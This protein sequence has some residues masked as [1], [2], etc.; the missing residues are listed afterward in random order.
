MVSTT[1][2]A[3]DPG[4]LA[5]FYARLLA[6]QSLVTSLVGLSFHH[7]MVPSTTPSGFSAR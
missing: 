5:R 6:G 4:A 3:A 7:P 1:V 2:E